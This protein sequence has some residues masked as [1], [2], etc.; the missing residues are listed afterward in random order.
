MDHRPIRVTPTNAGPDSKGIVSVF[1]WDLEGL[2]AFYIVGGA[3]I[4]M[5][6]VLALTGRSIFTRIGVGLVPVAVSAVWIKFFVH[7]KPPA[8]QSD[9]FE[10]HLRGRNFGLKPQ[11]WCRRRDPRQIIEHRL[12]ENGGRRV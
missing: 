11:R 1:G 9:V 2:V 5:L 10:K 7:A 8:Y 6:L 3:L 4:G 12:A